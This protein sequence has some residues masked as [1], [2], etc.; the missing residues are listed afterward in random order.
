MKTNSRSRHPRATIPPVPA[1]PG[2]RGRLAGGPLLLAWAALLLSPAALAAA[3]EKDS[4]AF[5][6]PGSIGLFVEIRDSEDLLLALSQ[7]EMWR[8]LADLAGQPAELAD[9]GEWTARIEKTISMTP[10]QAIRKL[11]S[12]RV[13]FVGEGP[14]RSQDAA[15]LCRPRE[16]LPQLVELWQAKPVEFSGKSKLYSLY[17]NLGLA[18]VGDVIC[19]GDPRPT[20]GTFQQVLTCFERDGAGSLAA[21]AEFLECL[22]EVPPNPHAVLFARFHPQ[23]GLLAGP[24]GGASASA[25]TS[26]PSS[27]PVESAASAPSSAPAEAGVAQSLP[28][29]WADRATLLLAMHRDGRRLAFTI[30]GDERAA[31][32]I[33][34][35]GAGSLRNTIPR[36]SLLS[37]SGRVDVAQATQ[38][39]QR[40]PAARSAIQ[41]LDRAAGFRDAVDALDGRFAI[42]LGEI[43]PPTTRETAPAIP[44]I[45]ITLGL[46]Q[47]ID[48]AQ[49]GTWLAGLVSA[50]NLVALSAGRAPLQ[51]SDLPRDDARRVTV[52]PL[53]ELLPPGILR[54]HLAELELAFALDDDHLI[55]ASH[56][57]WLER[58]LSAATD[59]P[60][61]DVAAAALAD[62][63]AATREIET[64]PAAADTAPPPSSSIRELRGGGFRAEADV[65]RLAR[66]AARWLEYLKTVAPECLEESWWRERQPLAGPPRLGITVTQTPDTRRLRVDRVE[67]D[68]PAFGVLQPGDQ[69][70]AAERR[71]FASSQPAHEFREAIM[72]RPHA[73]WIDLSIQR[74]REVRLQRRLRIPFVNPID[75]LTRLAALGHLTRS[76]EYAEDRSS[77]R[78]RGTLVVELQGSALGGQ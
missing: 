6:A 49:A 36:E 38:N 1:S 71:E 3:P 24:P 37:L 67:P 10:P 40:L 59:E 21:D 46:K 14:G 28:S 47:P 45:A 61:R 76:I 53:D 19:F 72:A 75:W 52:V 13:A 42:A 65:E 2:F 48:A 77:P 9:T 64:A 17:A 63:A 41:F 44:A 4:L 22:R 11:F 26:M 15:V 73:T 18:A 62:A 58:V 43:A 69:I 57:E 60:P 7:P 39:L 55:F 51:S 8:L 30:V 27:A 5:V 25:P 35:D 74:D 12:D 16:A 33:T 50:Y 56:R 32:A 20:E 54:E 23:H 68:S 34:G 70:F 29:L 78:R 66:G 31:L